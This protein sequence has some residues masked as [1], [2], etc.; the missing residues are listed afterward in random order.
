MDRMDAAGL[1]WRIYAPG[2]SG[3]T[4]PFGYG[5]AICPTFAE[6]LN[7]PQSNNVPSPDQVMTDAQSGDLPNLSIVIPSSPNSQ[8]NGSSMLQ[9][10]NWIGSVVDA[11]MQGPDWNTT[12]IFITWDDCG[13]FYDEVPP[14]P[15]LG[16][17]VPMIIVSP[18]AR[19]GY[20]DRTVASF[21]SLLAFTEHV[22]ALQPLATADASAYD[23]LG[24]FDFLQT[25]LSSISLSR[26]P[27]PQPER[28]W[29]RAHPP[30]PDS[31]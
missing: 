2:P 20:T 6:C 15:G 5:W 14:P 10:D 4:K 25:P 17:R 27:I 19:A 30:P 18:Y 21:A 23:Y 22:L 24:A 3:T 8:H 7:G 13:C 31:T 9:G 29:L 1:T 11:I 16:I 28:E 12:A 26:T